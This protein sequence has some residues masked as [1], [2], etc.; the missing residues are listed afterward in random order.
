[1]SHTFQKFLKLFYETFEDS[2]DSH[3]DNAVDDD[4]QWNMDN[5]DA[6]LFCHSDSIGDLG[7][8]NGSNE[9]L[10]SRFKKKLVSF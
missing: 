4:F 5:N 9:I 2:P 6:Q 3:S 1:M 7:L 8:S 10:N